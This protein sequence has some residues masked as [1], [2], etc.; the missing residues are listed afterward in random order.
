VRY[1]K[2][3]DRD[4]WV[5]REPDSFYM[6]DSRRRVWSQEEDLICVSFDNLEADYSPLIEL[7][8]KEVFIELI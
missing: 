3:C 1:F 2:D 8:K 6:F 5:E 7:D 4:I